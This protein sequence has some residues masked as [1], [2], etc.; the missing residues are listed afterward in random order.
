MR[1]PV[2]SGASLGMVM[3]SVGKTA[4]ADAL[5]SAEIELLA[6]PPYCVPRRESPHRRSLPVC[7]EGRQQE[8]QMHRRCEDRARVEPRTP[9]GSSW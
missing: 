5:E 6:R 1:L 8:D 9:W 4:P 7:G 2:G 3:V